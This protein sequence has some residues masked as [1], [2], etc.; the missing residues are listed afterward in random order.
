[1][2]RC[3]QH[4]SA[5]IL[6]VLPGECYPGLR[7]VAPLPE[8]PCALLTERPHLAPSVRRLPRSFN[9][10]HYTMNVKL[11]VDRPTA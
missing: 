10:H 1:M 8:I 7:S 9:S 4:N 11:N 3:F 2:R 5:T 6:K